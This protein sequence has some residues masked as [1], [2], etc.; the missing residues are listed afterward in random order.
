VLDSIA[1]PAIAIRGFLI[2]EILELHPYTKIA[3]SIRVSD[4]L[5]RDFIGLF[6]L[7]IHNFATRIYNFKFILHLELFIYLKNLEIKELKEK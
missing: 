1:K 4:L 5:R 3:Q 6:L 7:N 2:F